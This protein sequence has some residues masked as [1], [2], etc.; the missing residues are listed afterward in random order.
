MPL[1]IITTT[2]GSTS[3]FNAELNETYHSVH[4]A[5]TESKH[6]FI[7][8]GLRHYISL[9]N[10]STLNIFEVGLGTGL[11]CLLTV[12]EA[13]KHPHIQFNYTAIDTVSMSEEMVAVLNYPEELATERKRFQEIHRLPFNQTLNLTPNFTLHKLNGNIAQT[14]IIGHFD[15]VYFDAFGPDKQPE[16]WTEAILA[17]MYNVLNANGLLVTY[18][19]KGAFKRN[20]KALG[21]VVEGIPGPPPKR[22]MTRAQKHLLPASS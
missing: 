8:A 21:F 1:Q 13:D 9:Y 7:N 10:P 2:D 22:E 19:A 6:V 11:N 12:L 20:L 5:I 14:D 15:L 16:M 18:C 3:L 17:K 4:G